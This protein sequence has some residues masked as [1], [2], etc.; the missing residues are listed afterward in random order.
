MIKHLPP[1]LQE[2]SRRYGFLLFLFF[3]FFLTAGAFAQTATVYTNKP[4]YLPGDIV[5]I[6]GDGW[7]PGEQVKLDVDH[8]TISHGNTILYATADATGHIYNNQY[9]IQ[10]IHL[11]ELFIL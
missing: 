3:S 2:N 11:G 8:S 7:K 4:D 6:E 10:Q 5:V 9:I 1:I